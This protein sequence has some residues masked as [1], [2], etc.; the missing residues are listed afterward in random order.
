MRLNVTSE[1]DQQDERLPGQL[2]NQSGHCPLTG[3]CFVPCLKS[4]T[5]K[6]YMLLAL[7]TA[8]RSVLFCDV[9]SMSD[10]GTTVG[11]WLQEHVKQSKTGSKGGD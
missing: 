11:F 7:V 5:L 4:L 2:P 3:P 10:N 1:H 8:Q 9:N 6:T